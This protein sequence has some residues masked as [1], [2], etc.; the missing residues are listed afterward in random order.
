MP[1]LQDF[2]LQPAD[3]KGG[4]DIDALTKPQL[5]DLHA[6]IEQKLGGLELGSINLV[7]ET[8]LQV[9]RAKAL[10][11]QASTA[12]DA[13]LNQRAQVQNSLGTLIK[14]LIKMQTSL[15][16]SERIK[17]IQG[18][19]IK[20]VKTLPAKQQ[21]AFFDMLSQEFDREAEETEA[22]EVT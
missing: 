5:L 17:R 4:I 16:N 19:V 6:K 11:E 1:A 15:F 7:K 21:D 20:I 2:S 12:A 14:D 9:H 8:L 10:Q 22:V 18:A 3:N 13:P